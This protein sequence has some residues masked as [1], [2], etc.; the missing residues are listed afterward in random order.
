MTVPLAVLEHVAGV[1]DVART[2]ERKYRLTRPVEATHDLAALAQRLDT[3]QLW[4]HPSWSEAH[5]TV[6]L[7]AACSA[8]LGPTLAEH[9][10]R[11]R[12]S[13][14]QILET[15]GERVQRC[16]LAI[17]AGD[18]DAPREL[19]QACD[20]RELLALLARVGYITGTYWRGT[21]GATGRALLVDQLK[22]A[23]HKLE[24][25]PDE[26]RR[27]RAEPDFGWQRPPTDAERSRRWLY[28]FDKHNQYLTAAQSVVLGAGHVEFKAEPGFHARMPAYWHVQLAEWPADSTLP[29]PTLAAGPRRGD[30][31][32]R[33]LTTPSVE[34]ALSAGLVE[35]IAAAWYWPIHGRYLQALATLLRRAIEP[36]TA[37]AEHGDRG[38]A[39]TRGVLKA[40]YAELLSG[41]LARSALADTDDPLYRRDWRDMVKAEA[42]C[43]LWYS[44]RPLAAA[45]LAP[46]AVAR[47]SIYLASDADTP[48][49]ALAGLLRLGD[50]PAQWASKGRVALADV[51]YAHVD[52]VG[53]C[54]G[55]VAAVEA[56]A[57]A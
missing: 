23:G 45:G 44:L 49:D 27:I 37:K 26:L 24:P 53:V 31:E 29:N 21:A 20:G 33:W 42:R 13:H 5:P 51:A 41:Y 12:H 38:A 11:P 25:L 16:Q 9:A 1:G 50:R 2:P 4:L 40:I 10:E 35:S 46:L 15:N 30:G 28:V 54:R 19:R 48:S 43:R 8:G 34:A 55:L 32:L 22:R 52:R 6:Q 39:L 57:A 56:C 17:L 36:L 3:Y 47:D 18:R 7:C 14:W